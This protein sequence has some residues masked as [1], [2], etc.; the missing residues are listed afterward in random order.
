MIAL[1]NMVF[2]MHCAWPWEEKDLS[3]EQGSV[4]K[5]FRVKQQIK[6]EARSSRQGKYGNIFVRSM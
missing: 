2:K 5:E 6:T 3:K 1:E 4:I